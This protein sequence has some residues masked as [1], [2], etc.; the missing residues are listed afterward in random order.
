MQG[1]GIFILLYV[2]AMLVIGIYASKKIKTMDDFALAGR[3]LTTPVLVGTLL[4]SLVG[5]ATVVG[6]TGSFYSLGVDWWMTFAGTVAGLCLAA[7]FM[8]ERSRRLKQYT[9]PDLLDLRYDGKTRTIGSL[10]II[11]GDIALTCV[12]IMSVGGILTAFLGIP[13]VIGLSLGTVAFIAIAFYGGMLGVALTDALQALVIIGGLIIGAGFA[14]N[15]AGGWS[16]ITSALPNDYFQLFSHIK[17]FDGIG[18]ALAILGTIAVWQSI[19]FS[20]VFAAKNPKTAKKSVIL[21]IPSFGLAALCVFFI[22]MSARAMFGGGIA[23]ANVFATVT[24][25]VLHPA[26]ATLLLAVVVGALLT[27]TNS[28]LLSISINI[29]RDF[30]QKFFVPEA[31]DGRLVKVARASV[32]LIGILAYLMALLM[33]D[34]VSAIVFTYTMYSA[35]LLIPL[36]GG[37]MWKRANSTGGFWGILCGA[38][39]AV[40][41][42][43]AG[44]P[45]GLH[46]MLPAALASALALIIGS[47]ITEKPSSEQL[48]V[49][50]IMNNKLADEEA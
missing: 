41:W 43:F 17:L 12:Q 48:K 1:Y 7:F 20:R 9:L 49:F 10:M 13:R 2:I 40:V 38:T 47:L 32:L 24:T 22:G 4:A 45:L 16:G 26:V 34:I 29:T 50:D 19:I 28:I 35:A 27:T 8:A 15:Y 44:K 33:P 39:V 36:Y 21:L 14:F 3:Q 23:P 30:Y 18:N 6:W 46:P 31:D 11:V 5:G 42:H 37:Y 25:E